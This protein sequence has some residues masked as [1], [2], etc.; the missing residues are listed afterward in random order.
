VLT[1]SELSPSRLRSSKREQPGKQAVR[2]PTPLP[3]GA[4]VLTAPSPPSPQL[5]S[6][7][8]KQPANQDMRLP[9]PLPRG[10]PVPAAPAPLPPQLRSSGKSS[11]G[12]RKCVYQRRSRE[13]RQ[14][15]P[16]WAPDSLRP[17]PR[18]CVPPNPALVNGTPPP[19]QQPPPPSALYALSSLPSVLGRVRVVGGADIVLLARRRAAPSTV[20]APLGSHAW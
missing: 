18:P 9:T 13:V 17:F 7:T 10:A 3:R 8:Q 20:P 5:R 19:G 6:F 11:P 4:P 15:E 1:A 14:M 12:S 2:L 16:S